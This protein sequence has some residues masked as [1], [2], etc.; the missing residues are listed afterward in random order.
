MLS[1]LRLKMQSRRATQIARWVSLITAGVVGIASLSLGM[2]IIFL[3]AALSFYQTWTGR[4]I[5]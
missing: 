4:R 3:F 5:I 2:R 1:A